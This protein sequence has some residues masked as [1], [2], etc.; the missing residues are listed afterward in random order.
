MTNKGKT[1]EYVEVFVPMNKEE[2]LKRGLKHDHRWIGN[3]IF[4]GYLAKYPKKYV[5]EFERMIASEIRAG[6]RA[7]RCLIPNGKGGFIRCPE[8]NKCKDCKLKVE[9]GF[10][11]NCPLSLDQLWT[12]KTEEGMA[13]DIPDPHSD[14]T[15]DVETFIILADLLSFLEEN[16][17]K[18]YCLIYEMMFE[19]CSTSEIAK[20]FGLPWSTAK[21][22]IERIRKIAQEHTGLTKD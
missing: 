9:L 19:A 6:K 10:T 1:E 15:S 16:Y 5:A 17:G 13:F 11:T 7:K 20:A 4:D 22:T 14:F 8:Y 21:D 2:V 12:T 18:Q 3:E